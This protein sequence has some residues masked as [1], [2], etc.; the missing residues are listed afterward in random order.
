MD[1]IQL[2]RCV[3]LTFFELLWPYDFAIFPIKEI[4]SVE[5]VL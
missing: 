1:L 2:N 5:G 3:G 4:V